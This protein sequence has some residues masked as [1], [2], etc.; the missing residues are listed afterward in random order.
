MC[1][2]KIEVR[3]IPIPRCIHEILDYFFRLSGHPIKEDNLIGFLIKNHETLSIVTDAAIERIADRIVFHDVFAQDMHVY[4]NTPGGDAT[5]EVVKQGV[6]VFFNILS[7]I[8]S[9]DY[10]YYGIDKSNMVFRKNL[11]Q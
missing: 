4:I 1:I 7:E 5:F 10:I 9:E 2:S 11:V 8:E 6:E 3:K